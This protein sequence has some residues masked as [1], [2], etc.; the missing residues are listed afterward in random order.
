MKND[1][2]WC[3]SYMYLLRKMI[4]IYRERERTMPL[5]FGKVIMFMVIVINNICQKKK[6]NK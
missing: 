6:S 3:W 1:D 4:Y 5:C 2:K